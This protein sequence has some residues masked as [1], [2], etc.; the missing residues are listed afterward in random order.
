MPVKVGEASG[1]FRSRADCRP[2]V[3]AIDSALSAIAVAFPVEV[4]IP[5]KLA[6]VVT[7]PAV[8]PEAVPVMLVPTRVEGVPRLGV[9]RVGEV[10]VLLVSVCVPPTVTTEAAFVPAVVMRRS[11]VPTVRIPAE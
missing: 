8:R 11:P 1:A 4:T 3:L 9:V 7:L 6:L 5:V 2:E 10:R